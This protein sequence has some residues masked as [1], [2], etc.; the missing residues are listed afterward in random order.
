MA[1]RFTRFFA[2]PVNEDL[3]IEV[4][5]GL[6][7]GLPVPF[8]V[9]LMAEVDGRSVCVSR[10]DSAHLSDSPHRDVLGLRAGLLCKEFYDELDYG[11]AVRYAI[12]DFKEYGPE[13]YDYFLRH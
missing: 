9:R 12:A 3:V 13:Y 11:D 7:R 8:V 1:K 2:V 10:F 4:E 5:F 6:T